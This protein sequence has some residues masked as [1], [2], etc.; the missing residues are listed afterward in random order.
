[1]LKVLPDLTVD[2]KHGSVTTVPAG[3]LSDPIDN[4]LTYSAAGRQAG[5]TF[6]GSAPRA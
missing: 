2:P 4:G 5:A 1:L 3:S 6:N